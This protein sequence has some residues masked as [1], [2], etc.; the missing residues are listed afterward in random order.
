MLGGV[1]VVSS[2]D[3]TFERLVG[4]RGLHAPQEVFSCMSIVRSCRDKSKR[5][6][7]LTPV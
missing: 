6:E 2:L 3:S 5:R 7:E 4:A 1:E